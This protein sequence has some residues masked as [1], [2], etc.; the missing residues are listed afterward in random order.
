[1]AVEANGIADELT[2]AVARFSNKKDTQ[3]RQQAMTWERL[4]KVLG[5]H[6]HRVAKDGPLWSPTAYQPGTT[7]AKENVVAVY[8]LVL[9][10]DKGIAPD[11]IA[12][13]WTEL[14]YLGHTTFRH[15]PEGWRW[16]AVFPLAR[17]VMADEWPM[18]YAKL[19]AHLGGNTTDPSCKDASRMYWTPACPH[20]ADAQVWHHPGTW[21]DPDAIPDIEEDIFDAIVPLSIT[22]HS[23]EQVSESMLVRRAL[24]RVAETGRNNAGMWL[25]CQLR[26]CGFSESVARSVAWAGYVPSTKHNPDGTVDTYTENEWQDTVRKV[27]R[28]PAREP[29]PQ[30]QA[31]LMSEEE[32]GEDEYGEGGAPGKSGA[33][34]LSDETLARAFA[35]AASERLMYVSG[36][37]WFFYQHA[38]IWLRQNFEH[39]ERMAFDWM[40]E[41]QKAGDRIALSARKIN[42]VLAL[43]KNRL[44][45]RRVDEL[46]VNANLIGLRNLVFDLATNTTRPHD[47]KNLLTQVRPYDY[48][49]EAICDRWLQFLDETLVEEDGV[50][51]CVEWHM[52]LQEF[53]GYLLVPTS[54][55]QTSMFWLGGGANGK[56]VAQKVLERLVGENYVAAILIAK[57]D[58]PYHLAHLHG[59]LFAT[60]S[61][62]DRRA[63]REKGQM[64]KAIIGGDR[65]SGRRPHENVFDYTPAV[66]V[67]LTCNEMPRTDDTT[68]GYFRRIIPM[69]WRVH[70]A[71]G[72]QDPL[73]AETLRTEAPGI[74]NWALVGLRRLE[75]RGW[76]FELPEASKRLLQQYRDEEDNFRRFVA[77]LC[78]PC[79]QPDGLHTQV[80]YDAYCRFCAG[81]G[82]KEREITKGA[83]TAVQVQHSFC[84]FSFSL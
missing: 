41:R 50:T 63:L 49:P 37:Q 21:L 20:G 59:K 51:P 71:D 74:F 60:I 43:A 83:C 31:A 36:G 30:T 77:E 80:F 34:G 9:D 28:R 61:E 7:R 76:R 40:D 44:G 84:H 47:P 53:A 17:P 45:P 42:N 67:L 68:E 73:L 69:L 10:F 52:L 33:K 65:V 81:Q 29:W 57:L 26:D 64:L 24:D 48:D 6:Q 4:R 35:S 62:I 72:L 75:A 58:D 19:S 15:T 79:I 11:V 22:G 82:E 55:A 32:E 38:G 14:E 54:R 5:T 8:A 70:F 13:H 56:G 23:S 25:A 3:V 16:R 66:R 18:V 2:L 12:R 1:M 78:E 27:Y 39:A 46:D